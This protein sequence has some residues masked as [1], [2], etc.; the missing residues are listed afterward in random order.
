MDKLHFEYLAERLYPYLIKE[1]TIMRES[2]KPKEQVCLFLRYVASGESYRS[3]EYQFRIG[4]RSISRIIPKVAKALI[5]KMQHQYLKT[6]NTAEEWLVISEKFSQRW[7]FPNMIGAVDGKHI[8]IEQ[9]ANSG[10]HYRN[11]KGTD[12]IILMAVV[13]P[14]YQSLFADVS[15]NGRN[16]NGGNWSQ[17]PMKKHSKIIP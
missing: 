16:S 15:M 5:D 10:S 12:S 13:G 9:P 1:D 3:L 17:S 6:A 7:N 11:Y 8:V 4:R 2:I 14:E